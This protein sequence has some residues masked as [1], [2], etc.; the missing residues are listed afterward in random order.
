MVNVQPIYFLTLELMLSVY[1][2][3]CCLI[4]NKVVCELGVL[5]QL[6][7]H[8]QKINNI[9]KG[10]WNYSDFSCI[11]SYTNLSQNSLLKWF[12]C[13]SSLLYDCF[14]C[15]F[16]NLYHRLHYPWH[17]RATWWIDL[18]FHLIIIYHFFNSLFV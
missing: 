7:N 2:P 17:P 12:I 3:V 13:E 14:Q 6:E 4:Y 10:F 16:C 9:H 11:I 5:A 18:P 15:T 8:K 1:L